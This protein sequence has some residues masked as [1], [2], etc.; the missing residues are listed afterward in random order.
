MWRLLFFAFPPLLQAAQ[1]FGHV[2]LPQFGFRPGYVCLNHGSY[3]SAPRSV[4]ANATAWVE[5]CEASPDAFFRQG[6]GAETYFDAQDRVRALMAAYINADVNDTVFVD[7]ASNGVNAVV[8]SLARAMPPGK[9]L[10]L[11]NTACACCESGQ[12]AP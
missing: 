2:L 6:L 7:N 10:L 5:L 11:L 9:K 4:T 8:R 3:G 1:Q 12:R